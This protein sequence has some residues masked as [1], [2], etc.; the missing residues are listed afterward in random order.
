[1]GN[2]CGGYNYG[3]QGG[4]CPS[5]GGGNDG[6]GSVFVLIVVLFILLIIVGSVIV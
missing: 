6:N 4:Q 2:Y 3:W 5:Y 1:M